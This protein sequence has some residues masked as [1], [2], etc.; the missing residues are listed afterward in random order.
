[1]KNY[2]LI[3]IITPA[4]NAAP[5]IGQTINSVLR[6]TYPHWELLICDDCSTDDTVKIIKQFN[7]TDNRI[8]LLSTPK[9]TGSP[10]IPRNI[11]LNEAKG[12]YIAFLDADDSWFP[13][14]LEEQLAFMENNHY[15]FVY[16][17]YEKMDFQGKRKD[18]Y[19]CT[20]SAS[21]F[22]DILESN[23]I[24][25]L[26]VLLRRETIEGIRFKQFAKE[27][28]VFW[29]EILRTKGIVAYNTNKV[30]A[31]YREAKNS[32]SGNKVKMIKQQWYI[33][34]GVEKV[35]RVPAIYFM[36]IFIIKGFLK[37]LK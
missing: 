21:T 6:Q 34:R 19:V 13:E 12:K 28:Y 3:S 22:W 15:D 25:C 4:Y 8:R 14:K 35:K 33:L 11:A 1:M 7:A 37:Y 20:K 17:N 16:S 26:T 29:L 24:P 5:F 2:G 32:R 18:R 27:D 9:N 31:L 30:H 23:G 10:S 36:S